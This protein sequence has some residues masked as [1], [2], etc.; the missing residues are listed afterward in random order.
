MSPCGTASAPA[1]AQATDI[2]AH[3]VKL[4]NPLSVAIDRLGTVFIA[5][6]SAHGV[7]RV[8]PEG[9][10]SLLGSKNPA[11]T[12]RRGPAEGEDDCGSPASV[13]VDPNGYLVV[14]DHGNNRV[15]YL[16]TGGTTSSLAGS[17]KPGFA[18]DGGPAGYALL[19]SPSG[20]AADRAGNIFIADTGNHRVRR[21]QASTGIISTIAGNGSPGFSG[22]GGPATSASLMSPQGLAVDSDGNLWIAD[23]GNNRIRRVDASSDVIKTVA[24]GGG[25]G[26]GGDGGPATRASLGGPTAVAVDDGGNLFIAD[27]HNQRIRRVEADTGVITTVAGNGRSGFSGDDGQATDAT[28]SNPTGLTLDEGDSLYIADSLNHR[29]RRIDLGSGVI[30]TVAG[31]GSGGGNEAPVADAGHDQILECTSPEGTLVQLDGSESSDPEGGT[32]A[33][34]WTGPF[35]RAAS[36]AAGVRPQ[37]FLPLGKSVVR[38]SVNNGQLVSQPARTTVEIRVGLQPMGEALANMVPEGE[39]IPGRRKAWK[40]GVNLPLGLR[41]LC[42][43]RVLRSGEVSPPRIVALAGDEGPVS[44]AAVCAAWRKPEGTCLLFHFTDGSWT[45]DL[46]TANFKRGTYLATIEMPD[47]RRFCATF[48]LH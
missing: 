8:N 3:R 42:G 28:L 13:A 5:A 23:T 9:T 12:S 36:P 2:P 37:V 30:T 25:V 6:P 14:V 32:L 10:A 19:S 43:S 4:D 48:D 31:S 40:L 1:G 17:G 11:V 7:W 26:F 46:N 16:N 29:V 45:Y 44:L 41:L 47:G 38:L 35:L 27:T 21:V 33:L 15:C 39:A 34:R 24:G 22:D 18:G 20:V